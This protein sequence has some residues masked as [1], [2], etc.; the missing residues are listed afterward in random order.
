MNGE[1]NT[2]TAEKAE[3][4]KVGVDL[5]GGPV[6]KPGETLIVSE[7]CNKCLTTITMVNVVGNSFL[8]II[9]A[10]L[11]IIGGSKALFADAIHSLGDLLA[12]FMM[13]V[14]LKVADKPKSKEYQYGR[15]KVEYITALLVS[16]FLFVLGVYILID[17]VRDIY[18]GRFVAPHLV[19]AWG[20]LISIVVN[21][22]MARQGQCLDVRFNKPAIAAIALESR[23]DTFSSAAVL[24]GIIGAK[25]SF[26]ILDSITAVIVA[27][28]ILKSSADMCMESVTKLM[29]LSLGDEKIA[30]IRKV[31]LGVA[32]VSGV[33]SILTREIGS[34]AEVDITVLVDKDRKV[35]QFDEVKT[36]VARVVRSKLDFD[37]EISV[38]LKPFLKPLLGNKS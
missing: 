34:M 35:E 17:G 32:G 25:I 20:A 8:I 23:V 12:S 28:I 10:Y 24:A 29:D 9:K 6:P 21:E 2:R 26:P 13:F 14:A 4:S 19:T 38:R 31:V 15:G 1:S 5:I 27:I 22:I 37:G 7:K 30:E 33:G 36:A 11:G 18:N 16:G 3:E